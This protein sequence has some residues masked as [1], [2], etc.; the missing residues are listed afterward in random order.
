LNV[1]FI[2][3][4]P[5]RLLSNWSTS[6]SGQTDE[7]SLG[8][9]NSTTI[10]FQYSGGPTYFTWVPSADTWY[11]IA[12]TK[13]STNLRIFIDGVQIGTTVTLGNVGST[14]PDDTSTSLNKIMNI[15]GST[16][17]SSESTNMYIDNVRISDFAR[18]TSGFTPPTTEHGT[19][20]Q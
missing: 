14:D 19:Q 11:H 12:V 4:G 16:A 18:Y 15:G 13:E 8:M 20:G 3:V 2:T 10:Q 9:L 7:W 5:T 1:R 6:I 17:G